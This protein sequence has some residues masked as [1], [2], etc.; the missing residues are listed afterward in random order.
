MNDL[1]KEYKN[2]FIKEY[3]ANAAKHNK[4]VK[5][6][7]NVRLPKSSVAAIDEAIRAMDAVHE[8]VCD[9]VMHGY[10]SL[11]IDDVVTLVNALH[12]LKSEFEYREMRS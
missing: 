4:R 6:I 11:M 9:G 10:N 5:S 7:R 2:D 3:N 1:I 12:K 8:Q